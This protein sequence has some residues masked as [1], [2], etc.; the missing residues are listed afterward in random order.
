M[1]YDLSALTISSIT[2]NAT[3]L[4]A[5]IAPYLELLIGVLLAF[6][7]INYLVNAI[8]INNGIEKRADENIKRSIGIE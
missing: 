8:K 2:S 7:V 1:T 5:S 3:N 6:M 4:L